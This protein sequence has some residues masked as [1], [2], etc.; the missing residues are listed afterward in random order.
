MAEV[1]R[2]AFASN[3]RDA[4]RKALLIVSLCVGGMVIARTTEDPRLRKTLRTAA[5]KEALGLLAR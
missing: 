5:R 4:A 2:G 3:D 1:F